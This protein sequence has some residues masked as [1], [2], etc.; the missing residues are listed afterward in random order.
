MGRARTPHTQTHWVCIQLKAYGDG[1]MRNA[2]SICCCF[3]QTF[4]IIFVAHSIAQGTRTHGAERSQVAPLL[5]ISG[6]CVRST[7]YSF[8][9]VWAYR[10]N[11]VRHGMRPQIMTT[12]YQI[13]WRPSSD[14]SRWTNVPHTKT[15]YTK[16]NTYIFLH[17]EVS[18]FVLNVDTFS[19]T[20]SWFVRQK[21]ATAC[22]RSSER[23]SVSY[24]IYSVVTQH[25]FGH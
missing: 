17:E 24:S 20:R 18:M 3:R 14:S 22:V 5:L 9:W 7:D 8:V 21:A 23:V 25:I 13:D 19:R 12:K 11:W 15:L 10:I 16:H 1:T 2:L 4:I 6:E